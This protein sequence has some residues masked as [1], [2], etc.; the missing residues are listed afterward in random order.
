MEAEGEL[1]GRVLAAA[2]VV[3]APMRLERTAVVV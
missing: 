1:G 3:A 2:G